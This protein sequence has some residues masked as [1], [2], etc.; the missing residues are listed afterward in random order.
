MIFEYPHFLYALCLL[1]I[2]LIVHLFQFRK[3]ERIPFSN[4]QFLE[5]INAQTRKSKS[6]K[7]WLLLVNRTLLLGCIILAFAQPNWKVANRPTIA[8]QTIF[9]DNSLSMS[10][11]NDGT[12]MLKTAVQDLIAALPEDQQ[13]SI[14]T[15]DKSYPE[16]TVAAVRNDLL[17]LGYSNK[18]FDLNQVLFQLEELKSKNKSSDVVV[19]SDFQN[20]IDLQPLRSAGQK[21]SLVTI[22]PNSEKHV[23]VDSLYLK[24]RTFGSIELGCRIKHQGYGDD[25]I[26]VELFVDGKL[27]TKTVFDQNKVEIIFTIQDTGAMT[28]YVAVDDSNLLFDNKLYFSIQALVKP[29]VMALSEIES[30]YLDRIFTS[31]EFVFQSQTPG[32][33]DFAALNSVDL[34]ILNELS[35]LNSTLVSRLQQFVKDGGRILLIPSSEGNADTYNAILGQSVYSPKT[36]NSSGPSTVSKVHV[37]HPIFNEVFESEVKNFQYPTYLSKLTVKPVLGRIL[38]DSEGLP[39]AIGS[40]QLL[41]LAGPLSNDFSNFTSSPL[42]VPI[43]YN[44]GFRSDQQNTLYCNIGQN[45]KVEVISEASSEHPIVV[46]NGKDSYI[47]LQTQTNWSIT[48]EFKDEIQEAGNYLVKKNK[49][50]LQSLSFNF[51]RRENQLNFPSDEVFSDFTVF[52]EIAPA[53]DALKK[54][55]EKGGLWKWFLIFALILIGSEWLILKFVK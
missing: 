5:K 27:K 49:D 7:K 46:E 9:L 36:P 16:T 4:V 26:P 12:A 47:P 13:V 50:E 37:E 43:F 20:I 3:F 24:K 51:D 33:L 10:A 44:F 35:N 38:S 11:Q 6:I 31:D 32:Q 15:L 34:L 19:I 22:K 42:I 53:F 45:T 23:S 30:K 14:Y 28:G 25:P 1:V 55:K 41:C 52:K 2:P 8:L 48:L 21:T 18:S 54:E 39:F 17:E 40:A 29:N